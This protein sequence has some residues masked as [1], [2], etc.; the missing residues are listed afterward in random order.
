VQ[1]VHSVFRV[2]DTT[3]PDIPDASTGAKRRSATEQMWYHGRH[4]L[5]RQ[6]RRQR[7]R[8]RRR[9]QQHCIQ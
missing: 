4:L 8:Q 6:G 5:R 9:G 7:R 3:P 2:V 1:T